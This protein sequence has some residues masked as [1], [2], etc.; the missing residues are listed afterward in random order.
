MIGNAAPRT[1]T[2]K[3][4]KTVFLT[5]ASGNMGREGA[6][7]ASCPA[8]PLR[9]RVT[10]IMKRGDIGS[11][12]QWRC[13]FGHAFAASP[14]LILLAGHWYPECLEAGNDAEVAGRSAFLA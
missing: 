3:R 6:A 12:L 9:H 11:Q 4:R 13:C 1:E 8:R 14:T 2:L 10:G 7:G 5:G